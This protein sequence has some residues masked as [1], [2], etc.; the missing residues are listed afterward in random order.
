MMRSFQQLNTNT[1]S[2]D[3]VQQQKP[4]I[5]AKQKTVQSKQGQKPPHKA[6]QQPLQRNKKAAT[7]QSSLGEYQI[8]ENVSQLTGTDV[9]DAKVHYNS[10]KPAQLQAEAT[11]QG[12]EVHLASG[13]EQ[14]LGHELTHV[15]QQKQGRVQP[16]IQA[17][18]G[19]GINNDPKLEK[20]ADDIGDQASQGVVNSSKEISSGSSSGNS[21][22]PVQR[23]VVYSK[24]DQFKRMSEADSKIVNPTGDYT[25]KD[26]EKYQKQ[27]EKFEER[28]KK[29]AEDNQISSRNQKLKE[30]W[31]HPQR[32][33]LFVSNDGKM[34]VEGLGTN[35]THAWAE[36]SLIDKANQVLKAKGSYVELVA[37]TND[38]IVGSVPGQTTANPH[39]GSFKKV[40][41]VKSGTQDSMSK[42]ANTT[43]RAY[44]IYNAT[45]AKD[46]GKPS[47]ATIKLRDCGNANRLIMGCVEENG[48]FSN[49]VYKSK[50]GTITLE[51][52]NPN[53]TI[54]AYI[55]K[56]MQAE[57]P[58]VTDYADKTKAYQAYQALGSTEKA[59]IDEKYGLN[60]SARPTLGQGVTMVGSEYDNGTG[61]YNY[62]F[63]TN[64]MQSDDKGDY[65]ALEGL[66]D[67]KV[68]YFSMYGTQKGE[69]F[70]ERQVDVVQR[71]HISTI[72]DKQ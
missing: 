39:K 7:G 42:E 72:V 32:K 15:A 3:P 52:A 2:Q 43:E 53:D 47:L 9:T 19:V 62:H 51:T 13:K 38:L 55:Q 14:H 35:S 56:I 23:Y 58:T 6:K 64:I 60:V 20:E 27:S 28:Y 46:T 17:N 29:D 37:K 36:S 30:G 57:H 10:S 41:A 25:E 26:R 50:D 21:T 68:W 69:S 61:S 11:A 44:G 4:A 31:R 67:H 1:T 65:M 66:A 18:N 45:T 70:D 33:N 63:A 54:Q 22:A 8:K 59:T 5:Q 12:T 34:A 40:V 71:P 24:Q 49:R 48:S 16:T